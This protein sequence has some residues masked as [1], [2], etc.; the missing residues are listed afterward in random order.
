[1]R[2]LKDSTAVQRRPGQQ[3]AIQISTQLLVSTVAL[4]FQQE[5]L[6]SGKSNLLSPD[7]R[8]VNTV[9]TAS[10]NVLSVQLATSA[11]KNTVNLNNVSLG[12]TQSLVQ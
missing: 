3:L 12:T 2:A 6:Q 10:L 9:W 4:T 7:V 5:W 8:T 1:M 11:P